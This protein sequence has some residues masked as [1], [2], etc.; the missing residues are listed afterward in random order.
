MNTCETLIFYLN[1]V[2]A[3]LLGRGE[4]RI[5]NPDPKMTFLLYGFYLFWNVKCWM[6]SCLCLVDMSGCEIF[7]YM[8]IGDNKTI[9]FSLWKRKLLILFREFRWDIKS[10]SSWSRLYIPVSV[11]FDFAFLFFLLK[12][13]SQHHTIVAVCQWTDCFQCGIAALAGKESD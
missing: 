1:T 5:G 7:R 9:H 13:E 10:T 8:I 2:G 4:W 3:L 11:L 12:W 6:A